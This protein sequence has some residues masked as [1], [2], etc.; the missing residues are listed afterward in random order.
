MDVKP[1][2]SVLAE[3]GKAFRLCRFYPSSHPSVQQALSELSASLPSLTNVGVVELRIS[4]TGFL[5]GATPVAPRNP[6]VQELAGLLYAQGHCAL[7]IEPGVTADEFAA[8]I[9]MVGGA[10]VKSMQSMGV[11][12]Q[13]QSLPHLRLEQAVRQSSSSQRP[14]AAGTGSSAAAMAEGPSLGRRST[15]VFRPDALPPE[16]EAPRL[17]TLVELAAP[18]EAPRMLARLGEVAQDLAA[19]RDVVGFAKAARAL[20]R[21]AA[22]DGPPEVVEAA[23]RAMEAC[24]TDATTGSLI[25]RLEDSKLPADDRDTLVQV[26]GALG[27]RVVPLVADSFLSV[28]T[29][30]QRDVLLAVVRLVGEAALAPIGARIAAEPRAEAARAYAV[31]LGV[32]E[33]PT[34]V[35]VL[36]TLT[37][38]LN[39]GV[40]AAAI[41]SLA[42]IGGPEANRHLVHALRDA[43]PAVR[44]EAARGIA[45]TGDRSA[46]GIVMARLKDETETEVVVPLLEALGHLKETRAVSLLSDLANGVSGVFQRHPAAVRAAAIR[47]LGQIGSPEARA[48]VESHRGD[49]TP[50]L[51][52]AAEEAL[53]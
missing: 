9:W 31:F 19:S 27:A 15:G 50:E 12:T 45:W 38:H 36:G 5:L 2:E 11:H 42:R 16:I 46:S 23:R 47:A 41:A 7:E 20:A 6:P 25:S 17:I 26:L 24:V 10:G 40:R 21:A 44:T 51:K 34:S 28:V 22:G 3:V 1:I 43:N 52:A 13:L 4:P 8:L 29:Q 14:S 53:K 32:I 33:S 18:A 37:E 30:E 35:P 48:A 39:A 49:R